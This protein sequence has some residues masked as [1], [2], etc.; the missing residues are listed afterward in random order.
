MLVFFPEKALKV[1]NFD[2]QGFFLLICN[3]L[4]NRG[5]IYQID[6]VLLLA[7]ALIGVV[8]VA[9]LIVADEL[10]EFGFLLFIS[11]AFG[12]FGLHRLI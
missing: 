6:E 5:M 12:A 3:C 4:L 1:F 11:E 7:V 9:V 10:F 8:N 2:F